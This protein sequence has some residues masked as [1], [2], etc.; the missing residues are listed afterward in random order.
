MDVTRRRVEALRGTIDIESKAGAGTNITL[1][2]PLLDYNF[3]LTPIIALPRKI[4]S[5]FCGDSKAT[6]DGP[7]M[8][9]S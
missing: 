9:R 8:Q 2:L 1:R 3:G 5:A 4:A 6:N 7:Y